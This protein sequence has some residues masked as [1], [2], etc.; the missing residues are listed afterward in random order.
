MSQTDAARPSSARAPSIW[1]AE[2]A[3]PHRN[4]DDMDGPAF[5]AYAVATGFTGFTGIEGEVRRP[6]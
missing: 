6:P 5:R 1:K 4:G 2:E 3:T